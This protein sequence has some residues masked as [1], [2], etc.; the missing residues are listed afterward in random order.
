MGSSKF[1]AY[2]GKIIELPY[3][4]KE[5]VR[6]LDTRGGD[7]QN[8]IDTKM[9]Q[10]IEPKQFLE[11]GRLGITYYSSIIEILSLDTEHPV[12]LCPIGKCRR[13]K[14]K[15]LGKKNIVWYLKS[16]K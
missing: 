9:V 2:Y 11:M 7:V 14:A 10:E 15:I 13:Q 6:L 5:D 4:E 16:G 3:I 8:Y 12:G 1:S